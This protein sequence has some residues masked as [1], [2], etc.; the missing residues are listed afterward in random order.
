MN[1]QPS[2]QS[3]SYLKLLLIILAVVIV[4]SGLYYYFGIYKGVKGSSSVS[5]AS[6]TPTKSVSPL[7]SGSTKTATPSNN[8]T[9]T[10][11]PTLTP[12]QTPPAGWKNGSGEKYNGGGL[13]VDF[14]VFVKNNWIVNTNN[15]AHGPVFFTS[16]TQCNTS[17]LS[18]V[19]NNYPNC[20]DDLIVGGSNNVSDYPTDVEV[21]SFPVSGGTSIIVAVNKTLNDSDKNIIFNS[22]S[23]TFKD[24]NKQ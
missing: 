2:V 13:A 21:R 17:S 23:A 18:G 14:T 16:N 19:G 22:F 15:S 3:K 1:Q 8:L 12:N 6:P 20:W 4:G 5:V 24:Y 10:S 9:A 11:N 7:S